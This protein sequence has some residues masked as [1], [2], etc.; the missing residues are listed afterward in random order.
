MIGV[1]GCLVVGVKKIVNTNV[2]SSTLADSVLSC[3]NRLTLVKL[4]K[5]LQVIASQS[6]LNTMELCI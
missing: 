1:D 3:H 2:Y 6:Q 5:N 4:P